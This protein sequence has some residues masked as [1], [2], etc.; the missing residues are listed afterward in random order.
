LWGLLVGIFVI[1]VNGLTL[2]IVAASQTS[3]ASLSVPCRCYWHTTLAK[4]EQAQ[5]TP[6]VQDP[7][8]RRVFIENAQNLYQISQKKTLYVETQKFSPD[9]LLLILDSLSFTK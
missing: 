3:P 6:Y 1:V 5:Q 8:L 4:I 2:A 7:L 9:I